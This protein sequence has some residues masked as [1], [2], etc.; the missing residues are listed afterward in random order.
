MNS[1]RVTRATCG[2]L[3]MPMDTATLVSEGLNRATT[4]I[5]SRRGGN[6]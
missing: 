4:T 6:T 2:Q 5:A 3:T 1:A